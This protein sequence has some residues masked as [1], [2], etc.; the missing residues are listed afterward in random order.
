MGRKNRLDAIY[1][2]IELY[3][4]TIPE[5]AFNYS[6]LT[7]ILNFNRDNWNISE[8]RKTI[9]IVRY[10]LKKKTLNEHTIKSK[11][12]HEIK[13]YAWKTNDDYTV[14]AAI[15]PKQYYSFYT[16]L[17]LNNLT[18]QIPKIYYLNNERSEGTTPITN[19]LSQQNIDKA[20]DKPQ[21]R[22]TKTYRF[23]DKKIVFTNGKFTN[24]LGVITRHSSSKQENEYYNYTDLERTIID[25]TVRPVYSGGVFEVLEA[26]KKAKGKLNIEKLNKYLHVL[27]YTYPYNQL[28]GFY[29]EKANYP[30]S[31]YKCFDTQKK[32][33]FYLT[34]QM[35]NK[36]FN[37][38]WNV[39]YPKGME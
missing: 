30:L 19:Q 1:P 21:R 29:M 8:K 11:N 12:N 13:V 24:N 26:Y 22:S 15:K 28:I 36:V 17:Y 18:L 35:R 27:N 2:Q 39:Y 25:I 6:T 37:D 9:N 14:F 23:D 10:L 3:F 34:Y 7:S 33:R 38:Y 31:S 20:F 16:A 4:D 5:K 32:F